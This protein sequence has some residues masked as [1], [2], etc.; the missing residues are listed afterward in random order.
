MITTFEKALGC[1]V[2]QYL[3]ISIR[4]QSELEQHIEHID[5]S[6]R[7]IPATRFPAAVVCTQQARLSA[8]QKLALQGQRVL[9]LLG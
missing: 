9:A 5:S 4:T 7:N 2:L 6:S 3:I 1:W 8:P